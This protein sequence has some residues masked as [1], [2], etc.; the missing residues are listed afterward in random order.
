MKKVYTVDWS[1]LDTMDWFLLLVGSLGSLLCIV[2][3]VYWFYRFFAYLILVSLGRERLKNPPFWQKMAASLMILFVV[4]T[5][6]LFLFLEQLY[7]YLAA[8]GA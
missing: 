6:A 5:G 4:M 1:V 3:L 7:K 2:A 8:W